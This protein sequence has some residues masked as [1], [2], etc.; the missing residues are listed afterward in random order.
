MTARTSTEIAAEIAEKEAERD[1]LN[2]ALKALRTEKKSAVAAEEAAAAEALGRELIKAS[3]A[4]PDALASF[5]KANGIE[6][7]TPPESATVEAVELV[8]HDRHYGG[9]APAGGGDSE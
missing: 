4:G 6:P 9:Y 8:E 5:L 2:T 3:A 7:P 1:A